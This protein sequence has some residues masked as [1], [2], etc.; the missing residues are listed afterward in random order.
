MPWSGKDR[1]DLVA[2]PEDWSWPCRLCLCIFLSDTPPKR[3][4]G[5][6][7]QHQEEERESSD[8]PGEISHPGCV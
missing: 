6:P 3:D 8:A 1:E 5:G 7:E 2:E 4:P